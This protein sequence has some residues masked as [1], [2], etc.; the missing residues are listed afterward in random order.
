MT[1]IYVLLAI[2]LYPGLLTACG[3]GL[4]Y[5]YLS[6]GRGP[7]AVDLGAAL[8]S[9]EGL[10]AL[11]SIALAGLA[12]AQLPW[13]WRPSGAGLGWLWAW[14]IFEL[15]F[16]LPLL[17]ALLAGSPRV[18]RAGVRAAQIGALARALLWG[19]L[20]V[21]LT[22][23]GAWS[24]EALP[25]HLLALVVAALALPAALGWG[26]FAHEASITPGGPDAGLPPALV[27]LGQLAESVRG[28]ALLA[29]ALVAALPVGV[30][31]PWVG[32]AMVAGGFAAAALA[33]RRWEGLVPRLAL[34]AILRLG[35]LVAVPLLV[36]ASIT[37]IW[38]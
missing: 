9:R 25:A 13:P 10:A 17:P 31:A 16:L 2:L 7:G 8:R 34:P 20:G 15:A 32:L 21:A 6:A 24:P 12:L 22:A 29:A 35:M 26:P 28:G 18:V 23:H 38:V 4:I 36:V 19:A 11:L 5:G 3:L 30:A 27:A 37:L 1:M 33:L 14:A